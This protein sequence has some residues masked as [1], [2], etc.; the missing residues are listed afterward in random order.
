MLTSSDHMGRLTTRCLLVAATLLLLGTLTSCQGDEPE[1]RSNWKPFRCASR[2]V[3][4]LGAGPALQVGLPGRKLLC[5]GGED[6]A[7]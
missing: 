3:P 4:A 6:S 2:H 5:G 7:D 1:E